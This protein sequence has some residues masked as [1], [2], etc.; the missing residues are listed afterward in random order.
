MAPRPD[1]GALLELIQQLD[2]FLSSIPGLNTEDPSPLLPR[3]KEALVELYTDDAGNK[4]TATPLEGLSDDW[5]LRNR[6][7]GVV[8]DLAEL[9]VNSGQIFRRMT[10]VLEA[11]LSPNVIGIH[12]FYKF[13]DDTISSVIIETRDGGISCPISQ[14]AKGE[15]YSRMHLKEVASCSDEE[16]QLVVDETSSDWRSVLAEMLRIVG[17]TSLHHF[18]SL[19][20]CA[21]SM[22]C[23]YRA[24]CS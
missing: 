8:Q 21:A 1:L 5:G 9:C 7:V 19:R 10:S 20:F 14:P 11:L 17:L 12:T 13:Q 3:I 15:K 24:Q 22:P 4:R 18:I 23:R 2:E 6:H 16:W